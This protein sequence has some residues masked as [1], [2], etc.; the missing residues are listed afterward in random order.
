MASQK[1]EWP[2]G[3]NIGSCIRC[4]LRGFHLS[5]GIKVPVDLHWGHGQSNCRFSFYFC[6]YDCSEL[7]FG[8]D[9]CPLKRFQ[10]SCLVAM[11]LF[12]NAFWNGPANF[13]LWSRWLH[14]GKMDLYC[15]FKKCVGLWHAVIDNSNLLN[16]KH[17]IKSCSKCVVFSWYFL[18]I[19]FSDTSHGWTSC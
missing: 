16:L 18:T 17:D 6:V 5:S 1:L 19:C 15:I 3:G 4:H 9:Y 12:I 10:V 7:E 2:T 13:L 11:I 8:T 14:I